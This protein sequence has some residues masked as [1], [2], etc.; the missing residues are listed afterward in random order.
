VVLWSSL[1]VVWCGVVVRFN[2]GVV[3]VSVKLGGVVVI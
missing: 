2:C 3:F 1:V